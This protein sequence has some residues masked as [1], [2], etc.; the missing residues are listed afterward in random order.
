MT[1]LEVATPI[2]VTPMSVKSAVRKLIAREN[3]RR[4]EQGLPPFKQEE[5]AAGSGLS[6]S[7]I[8][9]LM[10]GRSRRIDFDT[11]N[12]LCNFFRIQ[13]GDL[14]EYTPDDDLPPT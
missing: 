12:G 7:V 11:I 9:N 8:S 3:L 4:A 6:Q 2:L 5:I 14:F 13:P 1:I 10:N